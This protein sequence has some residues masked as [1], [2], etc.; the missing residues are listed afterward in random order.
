VLNYFFPR[1]KVVVLHA[2]FN[3]LLNLIRILLRE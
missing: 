2:L 3:K 1:E